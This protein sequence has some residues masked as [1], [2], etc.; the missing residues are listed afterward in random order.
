[1]DG[2]LFSVEKNDIRDKYYNSHYTS[3]YW[4]KFD[5]FYFCQCSI[6]WM[7]LI[8]FKIC[9]TPIFSLTSHVR[10][11]N[12]EWLFQEFAV[13]LC[14]KDVSRAR[15]LRDVRDR[16]MLKSP[17]CA[18]AS[19]RITKYSSCALDMRISHARQSHLLNFSKPARAITV[20]QKCVIW[21]SKKITFALRNNVHWIR[22]REIMIVKCSSNHIFKNLSIAFIILFHTRPK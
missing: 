8:P 14:S 9:F 3:F 4:Y 13:H 20:V 1:M 2:N 5:K 22:S 11:L 12:V 16:G 7:F 15:T 17:A 6:C 10:W 18:R 19:E 21:I